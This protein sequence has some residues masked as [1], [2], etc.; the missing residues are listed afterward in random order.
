[1][2]AFDNS[3]DLRYNQLT[4][5]IPSQL[6]QLT[7]MHSYLFASFNKLTGSLPSQLGRL[8][9][10]SRGFQLN[11][12]ALCGEV[13]SSVAT[14]LSIVEREPTKEEADAGSL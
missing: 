2:T 4:G 9:G 5:S 1:L 12:N 7:L 6:G 8:T 10:F 14:V 3:L 11:D 13:I